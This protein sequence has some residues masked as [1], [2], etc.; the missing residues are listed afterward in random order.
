MR[1]ALNNTEK[2]NLKILK[3]KGYRPTVIE[4]FNWCGKPHYYAEVIELKIWI[5]LSSPGDLSDIPEKSRIRK[6]PLDPYED[7]T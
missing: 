5:S 7:L 4:T 2:A 6:P 1:R 3:G